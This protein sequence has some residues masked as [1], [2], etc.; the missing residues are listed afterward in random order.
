[1][2]TFI[3]TLMGKEEVINSQSVHTLALSG[4]TPDAKTSAS[5]KKEPRVSKAE[6][7]FAYRAD[8]FIFNAVNV[9]VQMIMSGGWTL[10]AEKASVRK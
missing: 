5:S 10:T 7:E 6:L 3:E 9:A 2:P 1:M 8:S 4:D